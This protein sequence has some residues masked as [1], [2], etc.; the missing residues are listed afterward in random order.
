MNRCNVAI[1]G[2]GSVGLAIAR[3]LSAMEKEIVLLERHATFGQDASTRNSEVIHGGMYYP[4]GSLKARLCVEGNRMLYELCA[5]HDIP[6]RKTGKL[7][8]AVTSDEHSKI[9]DIYRQGEIN[10]VTNLRLIDEPEIRQLEPHIRARWALL[11]PSSG[12]MDA[13]ALMSFF[14]Q[15][16]ITNG[17]SV[18]YNHEVIGLEKD[19]GL[20]RITIRRGTGKVEKIFADVVINAAGLFAD[21]IAALAG[22]ETEKNRYN[23]HWVKG[24]YFEID[25]RHSG[26]MSH[27]IYP[28]PTLVSLGIHVR[29]RLDGSFALGPNAIYVDAINYDVDLQHLDDFYHD[30]K[31]YLPFL[32]RTDLTPGI[33]GIRAKLQA[34]SEPVRDF[35]IRHEADKG[36]PGLINLIGIDSPALTACPAIAEEVAGIY[37]N[38]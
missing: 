30:A 27:L 12:I 10:G 14:E 17:V 28:T 3:R 13:E 35:V 9:E 1:I 32:E 37:R 15:E 2:A 21:K 38:L 20:F 6:H 22:I 19:A 31:R 24:E 11:S 16:A 7:I 25:R 29:L 4:T 26:K 8:I 33:A 36:L 23:I 18:R 5:K 34:E